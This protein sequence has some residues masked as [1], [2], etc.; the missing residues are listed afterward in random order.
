MIEGV[1]HRTIVPVAVR[2]STYSTEV[3]EA[4]YLPALRN[5][6]TLRVPL[7]EVV[8]VRLRGLAEGAKHGHRIGVDVSEGRGGILATRDLAARPT[9]HH[10]L[11][12]REGKHRAGAGT[13][14]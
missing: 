9:G 5:R 7:A 12:I 11:T 10:A 8:A 14:V 13:P 3:R 4:H 2:V 1:R 6:E